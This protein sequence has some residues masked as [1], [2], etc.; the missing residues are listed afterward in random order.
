MALAGVRV[1]VGLDLLSALQGREEVKVLKR[2]QS[3]SDLS[4]VALKVR[5]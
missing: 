3:C 2:M 5:R 4:A 1:C